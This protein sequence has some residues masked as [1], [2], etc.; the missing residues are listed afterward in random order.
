M[1]RPDHWVNETLSSEYGQLRIQERSLG[2]WNETGM[3]ENRRG[4][5]RYRPSC[6]LRGFWGGFL[7][8]KTANFEIRGEGGGGFSVNPGKRFHVNRGT[9]L[10]L[11]QQGNGREALKDFR[12]GTTQGNRSDRNSVCLITISM[13]NAGNAPIPHGYWV[14]LTL[15]VHRSI[16]PQ[17]VVIGM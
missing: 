7:V 2:T 5:P 6:N 9:L 10:G 11:R 1:A 15:V 12:G 16:R 13:A 4:Y 3:K 17:Y 14:S 8:E